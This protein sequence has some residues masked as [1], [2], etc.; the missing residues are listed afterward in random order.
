LYTVSEK[1]NEKLKIKFKV[2]LVAL[3]LATITCF[4]AD[5][6]SILP[7]RTTTLPITPSGLSNHAELNF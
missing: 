1:P 3:W 5:A 7:P 4:A 6:R 2:L